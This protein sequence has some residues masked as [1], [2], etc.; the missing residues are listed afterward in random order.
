ARPAAG[1]RGTVGR[2]AEPRLMLRAGAVAVFQHSP[3]LDRFTALTAGV[4]IGCGM[5]AF[6]ATQAV[7]LRLLYARE[8]RRRT[9]PAAPP[10]AARATTPVP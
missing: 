1:A 5:T 8:V 4:A 6:G 9:A 3:G 2:M 7:S 10:A